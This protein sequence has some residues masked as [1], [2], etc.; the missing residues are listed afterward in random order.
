MLMPVF[1]KTKEIV[2]EFLIRI[3][4]PNRDLPI[5]E[6]N[7]ETARN[8]EI[9][10]GS[11]HSLS[12]RWLGYK[13]ALIPGEPIKRQHHWAEFAKKM[14]QSVWSV[15]ENFIMES[16][17]EGKTAIDLGSGD[18][19]ATRLLLKRG[20][21]VIA[22]DTCQIALHFLAKYNAQHVESGRLKIVEADIAEYIP[23]RPVDLILATD[24][25]PYMDPSQ[26]QT[27]WSRIH[28]FIKEGGFFF[29]TLFRETNDPR[30]L[31]FTNM[32]KEQG[33]WFLHDRRMVRPLLTEV[34]YKIKDCAFR[35]DFPTPPH[36]VIQFFAEKISL[37]AHAQE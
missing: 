17:G 33:A 34:G 23:E 19:S 6:M 9:I 21:N 36:T 32:M 27:V 14:K 29:G 31:Q 28:S 3:N 25:F 5:V 4:K 22:V 13:D 35:P 16:N 18:S 37:E 12:G 24:I 10:W 20:W 7:D 15:E 30:R 1:P 2:D 8:I 26:F 11:I